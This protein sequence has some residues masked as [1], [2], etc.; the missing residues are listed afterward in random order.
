[1]TLNDILH[2]AQGGQAVANLGAQ[3]GLSAADAEKAAQAM[4]PA[5][6]AA[7]Q[8]IVFHPAAIAGVLRELASGDHAAS[9]APGQAP[10]PGAA[11]GDALGRIFGSPQAVETVVQ[12]VSQVSGVSPDVVRSMLPAVASILIGGL[13]HAMAS[14]GLSGVLGQLADAMSAPG[15]PGPTAP[16]VGGSGQ[17]V[18]GSFFG[19]MF[20][21]SHSPT[22]PEAA[23]LAA[24]FATLSAMF[25]S[26]VQV[27]QAHQAAMGAVAQ[28]F[29]TPPGAGV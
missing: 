15:G 13:A 10:A 24:G 12:H 21:G 16:P 4:I 19:S 3:Y 6:S 1:M 7:L 11:G 8:Q 29:T 14:L 25:V 27:A 18:I 17:G 22:N 28:S 9:Y 2:S 5:F 23:A 20:G 26:G